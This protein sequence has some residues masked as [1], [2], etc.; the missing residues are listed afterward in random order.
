MFEVVNGGLVDPKTW[1]RI[2]GKCGTRF[3]QF[4]DCLSG[5]CD[6]LYNKLWFGCCWAGN[7]HGFRFHKVEP[8]LGEWAAHGQPT[9][10]LGIIKN[11][12]SFLGWTENGPYV[13]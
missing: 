8:M 11:S 10:R 7:G 3:G 5:L 4:R 9:A 12:P 13:L 1:D 2:I 6:N